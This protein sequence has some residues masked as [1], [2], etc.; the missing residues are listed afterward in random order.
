[1][2][3]AIVE[4]QLYMTDEQLASE[5]SWRMELLEDE[6]GNGTQQSVI[7]VDRCSSTLTSTYVLVLEEEHEGSKKALGRGEPSTK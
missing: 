3:S 7:L 4:S 6:G 1:M 5:Q 2:P